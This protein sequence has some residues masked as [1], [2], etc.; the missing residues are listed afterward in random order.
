M[1]QDCPFLTENVRVYLRDVLD[2]LQMCLGKLD[3]ARR[4]INQTYSN[5]ATKFHLDI[6][7]ATKKTQFFTNQITIFA[8]IWA[9]VSFISGLFGMNVKIPGQS[10]NNL[11]SF[12]AIVSF[13]IILTL[14]MLLY[15]RKELMGRVKEQA[16]ILE[17]ASKEEALMDLESY[18]T[19]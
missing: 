16:K 10:L 6:A 13:L 4:N 8:T 14:V 2:H 1:A 15:F 3:V 19:L 7:K 11:Y 5:Y 17:R 9:P 12:F 18:D